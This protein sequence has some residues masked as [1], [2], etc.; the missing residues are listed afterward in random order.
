MKTAILVL[1]SFAANSTFADCDFSRDIKKLP[2]GE[3]SY[4]AECHIEVGKRVQESELRE[5]QVLKLNQSLDQKDKAL[6]MAELRIQ[7]WQQTAFKLEDRVNL[8]EKISDSNR[9][10]YFILGVGV[11]SLAV[12]GAGQLR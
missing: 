12:F 10:L 1:L 5:K 6:D 7:N 11:T 4:T 8:I 2:S 3:Y 9:V